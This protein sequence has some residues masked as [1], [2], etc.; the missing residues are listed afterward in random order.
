MAVQVSPHQY[1]GPPPFASP[2]LSAV[3]SQSQ[4][5]EISV[6]TTPRPLPH[7]AGVTPAAGNA[8]G[9]ASSPPSSSSSHHSS[10]SFRVDLSDSFRPAVQARSDDTG[11]CAKCYASLLQDNHQQREELQRQIQE[12]QQYIEQQRKELEDLHAAA[13]QPISTA[14]PTATSNLQAQTMRLQK[15]LNNAL[16]ENA[17]LKTR[18][19]GAEAVVSRLLVFHN[20]TK[21]SSTIRKW[22][23]TH[24]APGRFEL[25]MHKNF[26]YGKQHAPAATTRWRSIIKTTKEDMETLLRAKKHLQPL[27]LV[28]FIPVPARRQRA[29]KRG[30]AQS[31][32]GTAAANHPPPVLNPTLLPPTPNGTPVPAAPPSMGS[33]DA[34]ASAS[35]SHAASVPPPSTSAPPSRAGSPASS[36]SAAAPHLPLNTAPTLEGQ[37]QAE[38]V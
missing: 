8:A 19:A 20:D 23:E 7:E 18:E 27:V 36:L 9:H 17:K 21:A 25:Q 24:L 14:P 3:L 4:D 31:Q 2:S 29:A 33:A 26:A 11:Y 1:T 35:T 34:A 5:M 30:A 16:A 37:R 12:L 22:A 6:E 10:T 13:S 15:E 28:R 38:S 32:T